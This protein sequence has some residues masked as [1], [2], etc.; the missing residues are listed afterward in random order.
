ML[1]FA[2]NGNTGAIEVGQLA[3]RKRQRCHSSDGAGDPAMCFLF[4]NDLTSGIGWCPRLSGNGNI[5]ILV[6]ASF[7][8]LG[9]DF[10]ELLQK[11][12]TLRLQFLRL[13]L[14]R[15]ASARDNLSAIDP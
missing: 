7:R 6:G 12:E 14:K 9:S 4:L 13:H 11:L 10:V 1:V 3:R 8:Q 2:G 15:P 5:S